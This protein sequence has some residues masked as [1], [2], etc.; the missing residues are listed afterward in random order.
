MF[1]SF[2]QRQYTLAFLLLLLSLML[3]RLLRFEMSILRRPNGHVRRR[4]H[5][6]HRVV[7]RRN[8]SRLDVLFPILF[9]ISLEILD[10][11]LFGDCFFKELRDLFH[12]ERAELTEERGHFLWWWWCCLFLGKE[13]ETTRRSFEDQFYLW[14]FRSKRVKYCV[15]SSDACALFNSYLCVSS[16]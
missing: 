9:G 7:H 15:C 14:D 11:V 3:P 1:C 13:S 6:P 8:R 10:R 5:R 16:I 12:F 2:D 4:E